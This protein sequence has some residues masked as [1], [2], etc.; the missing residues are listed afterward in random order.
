MRKKKHIGHLRVTRDMIADGMFI[1]E[2]IP[3]IIDGDFNCRNNQLTSLEGCPY[4]VHGSFWCNDN[5]ITTLKGG[6]ILIGEAFGCLNNKLINLEGAPSLVRGMF[7]AGND[8]VIDSKQFYAEI[9]F[10]KLG[11]YK[12]HYWPE[13]LAYMLKHSHLDHH[14]LSGVNWPDTFLT[15]DVIKSAKGISKFNL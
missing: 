8:K 5:K 15:N 2:M 6:P 13:L 1:K 12:K 14:E 9:S 3:M 11:H 7:W 10:I 4:K